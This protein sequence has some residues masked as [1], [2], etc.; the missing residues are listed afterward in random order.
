[1]TFCWDL[2]G[3]L[4]FGKGGKLYCNLLLMVFFFLTLFLST[5]Y[6]VGSGEAGSRTGR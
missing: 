5:L 4:S 6:S 3:R 1:M 2:H